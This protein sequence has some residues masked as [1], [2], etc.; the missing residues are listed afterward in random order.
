MKESQKQEQHSLD[1][2]VL[3]KALER[4]RRKKSPRFFSANPEFQAAMRLHIH[5][6]DTEVDVRYK[7]QLKKQLLQQFAPAY[8]KEQPHG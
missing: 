7:E 6:S 8:A 5:T 2:H 4:M 1:P 3:N